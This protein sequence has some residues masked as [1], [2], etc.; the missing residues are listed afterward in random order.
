MTHV[1]ALAADIER[2]FDLPAE[3]AAAEAATVE[4]AIAMLDRG[5]IRVAEPDG[6]G[7]D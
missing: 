2:L 4:R 6:E 3:Q 7:G 5:E 1:H